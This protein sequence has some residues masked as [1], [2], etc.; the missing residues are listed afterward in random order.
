MDRITA[1]SSATSTAARSSA[2]ACWAAEP[3]LG[4]S[5]AATCRTLG[6]RRS[7]R[8]VGS[9]R[10]KSWERPRCSSDS[11]TEPHRH[12][13]TFAQCESGQSASGA[14]CEVPGALHNNHY[15]RRPTWSAFFCCNL[16]FEWI[17]SCFYFHSIII[18]IFVSIFICRM[19]FIFI[20]LITITQSITI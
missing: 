20:Y 17:M 7:A 16:F 19:C 3:R 5:A 11:S 15:K 14:A 6:V 1:P 9:T 12:R 13:E 4:R 18:S 2:P 10:K 8:S